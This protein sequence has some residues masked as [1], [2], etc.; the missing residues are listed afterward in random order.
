MPAR[1]TLI[2]R[3]L[4]RVTISPRFFFI[5]LTGSPRRPSLAPSS[6]ISTRT[7]P[8][9]DQSSRR[10][11]PADVSPD[12]PALTTSY[13]YPA[14]SRCFWSSAGYD[15]GLS[16]P[17]PAVRLSPSI[18]ILG[19]ADAASEEV[20]RGGSTARDAGVTARLGVCSTA[21]AADGSGCAHAAGA[22]ATA[23]RTTQ[24]GILSM[25]AS[26]LCYKTSQRLCPRCFLI[27]GEHL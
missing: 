17:Y 21:L 8:S 23:I 15:C 2:P 25:I 10:R 22:V 12:T 11:P 18:T 3:D 14:S 19:I 13:R 16:R 27:P 20:A 5:S 7:F 1:T 9:S 24:R 26:P 6:R 4:A